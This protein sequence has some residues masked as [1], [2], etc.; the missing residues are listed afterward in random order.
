MRFIQIIFYC[1]T[2]LATVWAGADYYKILEVPKTANAAEIKRAYRKLSLKYHPDKN[3]SEDA[4]AKFAAL[5]TAYE[6]LSGLGN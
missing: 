1:A 4:A 6:T 2:Y 3:P 5:S